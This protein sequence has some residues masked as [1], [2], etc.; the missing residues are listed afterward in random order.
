MNNTRSGTRIGVF[1]FLSVNYRCQII[2]ISG[3]FQQR[4]SRVYLRVNNRFIIVDRVLPPPPMSPPK[5]LLHDG[6]ERIS[7][8]L[9][10]M[11]HKSPRTTRNGN[12]NKGRL[13]IG[14]NPQWSTKV[15]PFV[16]VY[17]ELLLFGF[18]VCVFV[19]LVTERQREERKTERERRGRWGN[20][21]ISMW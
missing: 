13:K 12:L 15:I 10:P 7:V 3:Y 16:V 14:G 8:Y 1:K 9:H 6:L 18:H 17:P 2:P 19:E 11:Y 21:H 4:Y 5:D 20:C